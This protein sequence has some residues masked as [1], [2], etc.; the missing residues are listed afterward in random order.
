M[1]FNCSQPD[2]PL[3]LVASPMSLWLLWWPPTGSS[4]FMLVVMLLICFVLH[5]LYSVGNKIT[6]TTTNCS[7]KPFVF[8]YSV[9]TRIEKPICEICICKYSN[10]LALTSKSQSMTSYGDLWLHRTSTGLTQL[11][12]KDDTFRYFHFKTYT[13]I[14]MRYLLLPMEICPF[15]EAEEVFMFFVTM[16]I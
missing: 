7:N 3:A 8:M 15:L 5:W 9:V 13:E 14:W 12:R 11:S 10:T 2:E 1:A 6:T 16:A 4:M